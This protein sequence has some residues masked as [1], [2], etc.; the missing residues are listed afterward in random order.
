MKKRIFSFITLLLGICCLAG[1]VPDGDPEIGPEP[2]EQ[3]RVPV[4][5]CLGVASD[6]TDISR[7]TNADYSDSLKAEGELMRNWFVVVAKD[8]KVDTIITS[9][10]YNSGEYERPADMCWARLQPGTYIFYSFAN[11]QPAEL[12]LEGLKKGDE[13]PAGFDQRNYNVEIPKL[14]FADHW[15]DFGDDGKPFFPKGIP[16]SNKEE[17]EI[18]SNTKEVGLEVIRM[19]AKLQLNITNS[20]NDDITLKAVTLSDITPSDE[21]GNLKLFPGPDT[22]GSDDADGEDGEDDV[23]DAEIHVS[24]PN[25]ATTKKEVVTYQ[26]LTG[27]KGYVVSARGGKQTLCLYVNESEA[28]A[29]NKYLV[30]QLLTSSNGSTSSGSTSSNGS[31]SGKQ[32][33]RRYAML[34]WKQIC[35]NDF[36]AIPI[37]LEDYGIQWEVESF[38]PTGVLP[39][40]E[41]H[42]DSLTVSFGYY[43]EFHIKPT[44]KKLS[45]GEPVS[46][47]PSSSW[48]YWKYESWTPIVFTPSGD[49]GTNIFDTNPRWIPASHTIEGV[50]GNRSGTAIYKLSLKVWKNLSNQE[51]TLTRKVRF[52]MN[53][54][55]NLNQS[56]L[57]NNIR[58]R[59]E[60]D[61][62]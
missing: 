44:I 19:V 50:M 34:D 25:I 49:A 42:D 45:T 36:R 61:E 32:T 47:S 22:D 6:E 35:R 51:V 33:S 3:D 60:Y 8:N 37:N 18:T 20:T 14:V 38:S 12:G 5:L 1:C 52:T 16:M 56:R 17:H 27:D 30:L 46:V 48:D 23:D 15:T 31:I 10:T 24:R 13:L 4:K 29:E 58:H 62:D 7:A 2:S 59:I 55:N 9:Q 41:E 28:T 39:D 21:Q 57:S 26:A 53:A 40:V 43:G 11:I 54:V